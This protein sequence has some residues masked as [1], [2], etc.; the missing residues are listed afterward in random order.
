MSW[1]P[2]TM[3]DGWNR[4]PRIAYGTWGRGNGEEA[5]AYVSNAL[6]VG[7]THIDSA[8]VYKNDAE[9]GA[10]I[11]ASGLKREDIYITTKYSSLAEIDTSIRNSCDWFGVDSV[12]IYLIH[13][14]NHAKPDIPTIWKK[15]EGIKEAGLAKSIGVSKFMVS[16]LEILLESAKIK[17]AVNQ[18]M[19]H[20]QVMHIQ[21]PVIEFCKKEG[22]VVEGY[23]PLLP[24]IHYSDGLVATLAHEIAQRLGVKPEQVLIAWS[25]SKGVVVV[26]SSTKKERLED[27]LSAGEL[28]LSPEDIK[29][30]DAAGLADP[31]ELP[32]PAMVMARHNSTRRNTL[33]WLKK[34][35]MPIR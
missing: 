29:A 11:R 2:L 24:L 33:I 3:N 23:C 35:L 5:I 21:G 34:R 28:E 14:P 32:T 26:T 13:G 4:I 27:I 8:Q 12:D 31:Q 30:I 17:S 1:A 15:M 20:P 18:I 9:A 7:C 22:I 10:A 19:V 16:H 25:K 6:S